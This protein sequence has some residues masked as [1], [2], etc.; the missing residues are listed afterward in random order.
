MTAPNPAFI[1]RVLELTN[2]FR[3]KNNLPPL[4]LNSQLNTA[5]QEHSEDMVQ[6]D[7]L[8]HE[9]SNKSNETLQQRVEKVGYEY[10]DIAENIGG[11]YSTPEDVVEG[12]IQSKGHSEN[13]L[14]PK[15]TELGVGYAYQE[16]DKPQDYDHYW[17]QVLGRSKTDPA[18]N[19]PTPSPVSPP[20]SPLPP[21]VNDPV[22]PPDPAPAPTPESPLPPGVND[23]VAPPDPV[24]APTPAPTPTKGNFQDMLDALGAFESGFPNGDPRQYQSENQFGFIGKYQFGEP[25]LIDLGY[26]K[27]DS[28][29]TQNDWQD[30]SWTGKGSITSEESFKNATQAQETAIR[31]AFA[32]N[33][34]RM[35]DALAKEG[36]SVDDYLG[37]SCVKYVQG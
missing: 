1:N 9:G 30:T 21:G 32:L 35:N 25:L 10:S 26:Y 19:I 18:P 13:M 31:E 33:L 15:V 27:T 20:E 36:K 28:T 23:P 7:K 2:E 8:I 5:A 6:Q 12:W 14:N 29:P 17:T 34:K 37:G 24:P 11:G 3:A 22:A 16:D 4:T